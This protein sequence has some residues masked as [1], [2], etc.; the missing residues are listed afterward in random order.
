MKLSS[1]QCHYPAVER[2]PLRKYYQSIFDSSEER[3][4]AAE[5][6]VFTNVQAGAERVFVVAKVVRGQAQSLHDD[7]L[8]LPKNTERTD[9][10]L[11]KDA[12]QRPPASS[13][14]IS[15]LLS[16]TQQYLQ[17]LRE[18]ISPPRALQEA[19]EAFYRTYD[20]LVRR[21]VDACGILGVDADDA[22]QEAWAEITVKLTR[23]EYD[24]GRGCIEGWLR[25]VVH[26]TACRHIRRDHRQTAG[27]IDTE[28]STLTCPRILEPATAAQKEELFTTVRETLSAFRPRVSATAYRIL[29]LT[30]I[31]GQT[32]SE[33][34]ERLGMSAIN[35]R[36]TRHRTA[37]KFRQFVA[38][39]PA[40]GDAFGVDAPDA[41][42]DA[43]ASEAP[44]EFMK[45][46][47]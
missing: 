15:H 9:G 32:S 23:F 42:V 41:S 26:R 24:S 45:L 44:D 13:L 46:L 30:T 39:K 11:R 2:R 5:S 35:V 20:L 3:V 8:H 29:I 19:W 16:A 27:R 1:T 4:T 43:T 12:E 25:I 47:E 37:Q 22:A 34:G 14:S 40:L 17:A 21:T 31:Q 38:E 18:C 33:I 28:L 36:V 6:F 10:G 7:N